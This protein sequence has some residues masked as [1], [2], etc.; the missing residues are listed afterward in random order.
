MGR[1]LQGVDGAGEGQ[2]KACLDGER[3]LAPVPEE[4]PRGRRSRRGGAPRGVAVCICLPAIRKTSRGLL[5]T[6]LSA[7]PPPS[8]FKESEDP[9]PPTHVK[10]F[11]GGDDACPEGGANEMRT[12]TTVIARLDRATQYS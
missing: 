4:R 5:T 10:Q 9:E 12:L 11:A 1:C 7:L 2:A 3:K 8:P 6:R